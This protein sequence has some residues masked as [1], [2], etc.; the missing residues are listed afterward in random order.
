M[1]ESYDRTFQTAWQLRVTQNSHLWHS[2]EVQ[3]IIEH[4]RLCIRGLFQK[5]QEQKILP[6]PACCSGFQYSFM[7][8]LLELMVVGIWWFRRIHKKKRGGGRG[9]SKEHPNNLFLFI[10]DDRQL[11]TP[12]F[13]WAL[14]TSHSRR[15]FHYMR[16]A[17]L[18]R[19]KDKIF[20]QKVQSK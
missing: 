9:E 18:C 12:I 19:Q 20:T 14:Q 3:N 4:K 5:L 16:I 7:A 11:G 6:A 17:A 8:W 13:S 2:T 10:P 1:A 15:T